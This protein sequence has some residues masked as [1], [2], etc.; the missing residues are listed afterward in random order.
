MSRR[1]LEGGTLQCLEIVALLP[2]S[3]HSR[4][5]LPLLLGALLLYHGVLTSEH[6]LISEP[7]SYVEGHVSTGEKGGPAD[8]HSEVADYLA[9][10]LLI[11][12]SIFWLLLKGTRKLRRAIAS[13]LAGRRYLSTNS[14]HPRRPMSS[15]LQ[16][17][18]L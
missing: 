15:L 8:G 17:F 4:F 6:E 5:L 7:A 11:S 10:L 9:V 12:G 3:T 2:K 18:R 16:V 1:A 13:R 14:R